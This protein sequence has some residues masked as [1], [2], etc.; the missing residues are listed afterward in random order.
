METFRLIR[1]CVIVA[2]LFAALCT[3]GQ[4]KNSLFDN[5][6]S[7][8][9]EKR[10][11]YEIGGV[12]VVGT[13]TRDK[14]AIKSIV[15]LKEGD[16]LVLAGDKIGRGIKSLWRLGIF[17]GLEIVMDSI[18]GDKVYLT[19]K[20]EESPTLSKIQ[21]KGVKKS[22]LDD[23]TTEVGESVRIGGILTQNGKSEAIQKIKTFFATK[24][25]K[26]AEVTVS[27]KDNPNKA[28][29][30]IAEFNV[31]Q[32][33]R[34]KI[35]KIH[36]EGNDFV[37][38][39][40]LKKLLKETKSK[41]AFLKKSK[42]V[43]EDFKEDKKNILA[44]YNK[45]GY[46]DASIL[47]DSMWINDEANLELKITLDEGN[48]Y[49]YRNITW[50]GNSLYTDDQLSA[51][52]GIQPGD[53]FNSELLTKRLEFSLDGRDVSSLYMDRGYLFFQ[54]NPTELSVAND[55]IDLEMRI[56]EGPQATIDKVSIAG[57]DRTNEN[58]IRRTIRTIPGEKFSRSN[59]IRSQRELQ[60][61]GYFNPEN[62]D[63]N[64]PVNAERG[65]V[66]IEYTVE[67]T[68]S[69]QLELSA[70]FGGFSGLI[71]TLGVSFN[72]FSINNITKKESWSP[73]PT[74]DGQRLSLR[75]QSNGR[76]FRSYNASF[77]DPWFGGNKPNS[78]TVGFTG[79][80]I[81]NSSFGRGSLNILRGFL[82]L[83]TAL[84]FPDD[85]FVSNT[86]LN[87]ETIKLD[88]YAGVFIVESGNFRNF[89]INQTFSRS[90]IDQPLF[91]RKGSRIS[92]SVQFTPPYSLFRSD[93]FWIIG[94]EEKQQLI[95]E[96][97][98]KRGVR[99]QLMG[100]EAD[101]FIR[102][103]EEGR[104]FR[105]LEYHKWRFDAEWYFNI[106]GKL[107]MTTSAKMGYLGSYN[108]ALGT[109]PFERYELG[110]DGLSNQ[111]S[112]ITGT[113]IISLRG[114]EIEDLDV[115]NGI[116]SN[117]GIQGRGAAAIFN[118]FTVELRYPL[119]LN[120]TS[121]IFATAYFQAGNAWNSF[122]DYNPFDLYRSVGVGLRVFLPMFG[123]LGFDYAFGLDKVIPGNPNPKL[124]E[125]SKFS[126]ILGFEPD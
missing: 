124:G 49:L 31:D 6:I 19:I 122:R 72:N 44:H 84:K 114:Y 9:Y 95:N 59:I 33:D 29:S 107:V 47:G 105:Y 57:N 106:V 18:S 80:A 17:S 46:R 61:L 12:N 125:L 1:L 121:T 94:A 77:T 88:D 7:L 39:R 108:N 119:S 25:Y 73:L 82:G 103:L 8:D 118:K 48:Q 13:E 10:T 64:T 38:D 75:I 93:N 35:A 52:L 26:N 96:E 36:F 126:I 69:D 15:K 78:F 14:N 83:G 89:N 58:V 101:A 86:I 42:F 92:L 71:G 102:N 41:S 100:A 65:T 30:V 5:Y 11:S 97:N 53:I 63:I 28:N 111:N 21:F 67:E 104:K 70:G 23:L 20:L 68:P 74:G 90:S 79:T 43:E 117:N 62:M 98:L 55:S 34:L 116:N 27:Q 66:D 87:L 76:F 99:F 113:D 40:K 85:F 123:L 110:G 54:V 60:N 2:A 3:Y 50:K 22:W 45:L 112:G 56:Y 91:P 16:Q 37:S 109:V 32:K 4:E 120:P 81:D 51:I 115:N 24:G